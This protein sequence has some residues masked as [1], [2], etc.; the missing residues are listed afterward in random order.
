[1]TIA[2]GITIHLRAQ[3]ARVHKPP[4]VPFSTR[5]DISPIDDAPRMRS[6]TGTQ[7]EN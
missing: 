4:L 2:D 3:T 1:M 7:D 6:P 5:R